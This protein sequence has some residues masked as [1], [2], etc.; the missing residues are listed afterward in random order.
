MYELIIFFA[1]E[2]SGFSTKSVFTSRLTCT[3]EII[4]TSMNRNQSHLLNDD[5]KVSIYASITASGVVV[6][7]YL[8]RVQV[9]IDTEYEVL[10]N[11][12]K[13]VYIILSLIHI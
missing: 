7:V 12:A 3:F 2:S 1:T 11:I 5:T 9:A 8:A 10:L 4:C 6:I 13:H